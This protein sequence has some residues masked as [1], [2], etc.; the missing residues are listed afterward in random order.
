MDKLMHGSG[1]FPRDCGTLYV[2]KEVERYLGLKNKD[3]DRMEDYEL[4]E[5]IDEIA[6]RLLN[7]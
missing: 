4:I 2:I 5:Y 1:I 7:A 3:I 6:L